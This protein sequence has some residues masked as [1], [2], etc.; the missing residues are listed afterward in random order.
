M[1]ILRFWS[2]I[3]QN[4]V[5]PKSMLNR[6]IFNKTYTFTGGWMGGLVCVWEGGGELAGL[7]V[8]KLISVKLSL[9]LAA[10]SLS[11][12][13]DLAWQKNEFNKLRLDIRK[14]KEYINFF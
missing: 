13:F 7:M 6:P 8:I 5:A 11:F 12:S 1:I 10:A 9:L 14:S 2:V 4:V 3:Q